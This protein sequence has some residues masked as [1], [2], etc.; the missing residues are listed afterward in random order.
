MSRDEAGKGPSYM[1]YKLYSRT[2]TLTKD[3]GK[4][5]KHEF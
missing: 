3:S 1:T 5:L 4:P 2:W